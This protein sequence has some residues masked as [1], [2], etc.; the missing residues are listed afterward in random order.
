MVKEPSTKGSSLISAM[1]FIGTN[2][3][4]P[5]LKSVL[6]SFD[7]SEISEKRLLPSDWIPETVYRDLLVAAGRYIRSTPGQKQPNEFFFEMGRFE[8]H[9]GIDK[10]YKSLIRMFD[11]KFMLTRSPLLWGMTHSHG[12]LRVE[13]IGRSGA[14]IYVNDYP[15]PCKEFC[16]NLAGYMY[17]VGELTK[18]QMIQ[19]QEV[20]CVTEGAE[21]CKFVGGWK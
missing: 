20:E 4:E 16:Y 17:A 15:A 11:T 2:L 8:A 19:V 9:D 6:A 18:A 3:G 7:S 21:C 13:A 5:A 14:Y 1:S 10:Y 12:S